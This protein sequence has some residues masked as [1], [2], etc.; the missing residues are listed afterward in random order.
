VQLPDGTQAH[1]GRRPASRAP[2]CA[3]ST[4]RPAA[5]R[6]ARGDIGFAE[7]YIDGDWTTPD[8]VALLELFIA[9]RDAME[10]VIYGSWWGSLATAQAPAQPQHAPRQPQEHPRPLRPG[11]PVLPLWLDETMN[12]SSA[13]FDGDPQP[14]PQAQPPRCAARWRMRPEAGPAPAGD[15]LRLGRRGRNAPPPTSAPTSPA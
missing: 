8:L 6:C 1:F 10:T 2:R 3:C 15:R 14:M 11:Q 13:W 7:A 9:N 4:G 12:Y 5:R